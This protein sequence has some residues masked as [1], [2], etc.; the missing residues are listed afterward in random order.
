MNRVS[1]ICPQCGNLQN[2]IPCH[3]CPR[4]KTV[5]LHITTSGGM[6]VV[7][8]VG[9][10]D[11]GQAVVRMKNNLTLDV[12]AA[13]LSISGAPDSQRTLAWMFDNHIITGK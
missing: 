4:T 7:K 3:N 5:P 8:I 12:S 6:I 10:R 2:E 13:E 1:R 11:N 9:Y